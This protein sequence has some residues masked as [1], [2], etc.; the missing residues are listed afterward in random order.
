MAGK[1]RKRRKSRKSTAGYKVLLSV[2]L[3]LL[4]VVFLL[5][6]GKLPGK[7][8]DFDIRNLFENTPQV[9]QSDRYDE[10]QLGVFFLDVGQADCTLIR[11]PG[12]KYMLIDAGKNNGA[13]KLVKM[14]KGY[15]VSELE[16]M[17]LTHPHE[18]HVGGAD[19]VLGNFK[20]KTVLMPDVGADS[21]TWRDVMN[22]IEAEKCEEII[23]LP[24]NTYKFFEGCSFTVLAPYDT[25]E[26]LNNCSI[27]LR[28]DYGE[29][30]FLFTGDAETEEEKSILE[31]G[32]GSELKADV[33]KVGHHGSSSSTSKEF[34]SAVSP[35]VAVISCGE[36]NDYG[37]PHQSTLSA[38]KNQNITFYRT[39]RSGTVLVQ[40]NGVSLTVII[41]E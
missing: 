26:E 34:L 13:A 3:L 41:P 4:S 30:S 27:V 28:L 20:V 14:L 17:V 32:R 35:A 6:S 33:L 25:D 37:H 15:G 40:S 29:T 7:L 2:V 38:L 19:T 12:G 24:G 39:D 36:D 16:Y 8:K 11:S 22:A 9:M 18:D 1:K 23:P 10:S 31:N 5:F 21:A